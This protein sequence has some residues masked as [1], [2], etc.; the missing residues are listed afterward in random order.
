MGASLSGP[1]RAADKCVNLPVLMYHHIQDNKT[2]IKY[3]QTGLSVSPEYL[4]KQFEYLKSKNYNSISAKQLVNFFDNNTPL[5]TKPVLI[6]F[7]DAYE[8]SYT[9]AFPLLKSFG[10]RAEIFAPTGLMNNPDYLSW[11]KMREMNDSGIVEFGNHTWSHHPATGKKEVIEKE[12]TLADGQ[13]KEKGLNQTKLFAYPYGTPGKFAKEILTKMEY[14]LAFTTY[15][16]RR[17]CVS[18]RLELPRIRIGNAP[19]SRYGL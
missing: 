9:S 17:L 7:D 8:D 16:G 5:P 2:A 18:K 12:I 10:F 3:K 15:S 19:L 14:K 6:T 13:L 1:V 11:D 4:Q